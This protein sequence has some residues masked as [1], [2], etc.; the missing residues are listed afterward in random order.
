MSTID[1]LE[2]G[3]GGPFFDPQ[4]L[5]AIRRQAEILAKK[6]APGYESSFD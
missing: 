2:E 1:L 3:F 4:G 5:I 6:L